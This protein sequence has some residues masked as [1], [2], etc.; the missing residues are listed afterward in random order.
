MPTGIRD[1]SPQASIYNDE[2]IGIADELDDSARH[3]QISLDDP[4]NSHPSSPPAS[5]TDVEKNASLHDEKPTKPDI[6]DENPQDHCIYN[7][8]GIGIADE[9]DDPARHSQISLD[10]PNNSNPSSPPAS[11]TG[12]EKNV[13]L[14]EEE[15]TTRRARK[16]HPGIFALPSH[17]TSMAAGVST[18]DYRTYAP[19]PPFEEAGPASCIW[20]AYLDE[21]LVYDTD[22]LGNQRGQ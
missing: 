9:L 3:S 12:K 14:H 1:E 10:D 11:T 19:S 16:R 4:N 20:R 8:E 5:T 21:S 6:R 17:S 18:A 2:G 7:D 15:P 13:P 22:M